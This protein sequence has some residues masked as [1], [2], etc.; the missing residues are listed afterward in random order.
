VTIYRL[1]EVCMACNREPGQ[2]MCELCARLT[3]AEREADKRRA[4]FAATGST[5]ETKP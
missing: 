5:E 2:P 1:T 3:D 4:A